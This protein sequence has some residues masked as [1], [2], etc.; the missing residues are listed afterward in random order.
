MVFIK[1]IEIRGFKSYKDQ[2][3]VEPFSPH[4]NVIGT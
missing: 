4:H 1:R 2:T 3:M